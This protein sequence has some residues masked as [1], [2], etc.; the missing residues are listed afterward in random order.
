M[1][2]SAQTRKDYAKQLDEFWAFVAKH[3]LSFLTFSEIVVAICDYA[4][5]K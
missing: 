5:W 1:T 2:P 4:D 3:G